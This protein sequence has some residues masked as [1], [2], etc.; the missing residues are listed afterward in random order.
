MKLF[1]IAMPLEKAGFI[2]YVY[3][4]GKPLF[5]F[6]TP[7]DAKFGGDQPSIAKGHI[8]K[9]ESV[10]AAAYREASEELG[11][12]AENVIRS[13]VKLVWKGKVEGKKE[14]FIFTVYIGEVRKKKDFGKP[15]HETGSTHWLTAKEFADKG[16]K[17][18]VKIV[19]AAN[20][21]LSS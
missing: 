11:L 14:A 21:L 4:D 2:P 16:R 9:G 15:D 8:D 20:R 5:Y 7:S 6:M 19:Q 17:S 3:E 10:L 13:T 18:Q 1:E 12:K